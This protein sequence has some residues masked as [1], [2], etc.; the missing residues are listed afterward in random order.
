MSEPRSDPRPGMLGGMRVLD[1]SSWRPMPHAT[2]ILAD[3]GAEVLKVE[4]PGG[5]PMRAYPQLFA[6]IARGKRSI[7][8]DLR[9]DA[10]VARA[11]E[12][13]VVADVVFEAWRPGVADRLGLGYE[14]VAAVN[15]EVI[16]CS[17]TG[18]GQTGPYRDVPGH[19]VNYQALAGALAP[20]RPPLREPA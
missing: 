9:S 19:D 17:L 20:P 11:L 10:G 5:D 3:L 7:E 1:V 12:L 15:P 8:L 2:Q 18:Y 4:P 6:A 16:Y 14:A 13:A